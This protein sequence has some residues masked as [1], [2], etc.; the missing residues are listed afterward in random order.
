MVIR[1]E[2]LGT[3]RILCDGAEATDLASLPLPC[4]L[5]VYLALERIADRTDVC[6]FFW[7]DRDPQDASDR[8]DDALGTLSRNLGDGWLRTSDGRLEV[9]DNVSADALEYCEAC[10]SGDTARARALYRGPFLAGAS[11]A[12]GYT[13]AAW[14][15]GWRDW[16][17]TQWRLISRKRPGR[18]WR[19][20]QRVVDRHVVP[21]TL[22]YLAGAW[23]LLEATNFMAGEFGWPFDP[24]PVMTLVLSFGVLSAVTV[25][26]FHG[27]AGFQRISR[28]ELAIH[29][30]IAVALTGTFLVHP[31]GRADMAPG[32]PAYPLTR[33]AVFFFEDHSQP[34][35]LGPLSADLTEAVV[36]RLAN[37]PA[38]DVLPMTAMERFRS[39]SAVPLDSIVARLGIGSF[40]EG[41]VTRR[42]DSIL[43]TAQL[44]ETSS[45]A[46]LDSWTFTE[47]AS[48]ASLSDDLAGFVAEDVRARLGSEVERRRIEAGTRV[49]AALAAYEQA[50]EI[51]EDEAPAEW[52]TDTRRA[53]ALLVDADSAAA[54]AED[55]DPSWT[56][57]ILLR[58]S[59]ADDRSRLMGGVGSRDR[60]MLEQ[61]IAHADR[62]LAVDPEDPSALEWRGRLRYTIA[63]H[64]NAQEARELIRLSEA[65]LRAAVRSDPERPYAWWALSRIMRYRGN[66]EGAYAFAMRAYRSDSFLDLTDEIL[67]ALMDN[68]LDQGRFDDA[69]HWV[70]EGRRIRPGDQGFI[71]RR[72]LIL[73]TLPRPGPADIAAA[74]A[75]VD[76][77]VALGYAER[78]NEWRAYGQFLTAMA[79]A[80]A[81][82]AD[83]ADHVVQR[84]WPALQHASHR[85]QAAGYLFDAVIRERLGQRDSALALLRLYVGLVPSNAPAL[86]SE[87]WF[88]DLWEDPRYQALYSQPTEAAAVR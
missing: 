32:P 12:G 80:A 22:A 52:V 25:A 35:D 63:Q 69:R 49:P 36:H 15:A 29:G 47:A 27:A 4:A 19:L 23:V 74:W 82:Q 3:L 53:A 86:A 10:R 77:L 70:A 65:D 56:A 61:A 33:I 79:L 1:L 21:W 39:G 7:P 54:R 34:G 62:A 24:I 30:L 71:Q 55:L 60:D 59:I 42:G 48:S 68:A 43:T 40:V 13:F 14:S 50:R 2:T 18:G 83:S 9:S 87:T 6:R 67:R 51:T 28:R 64:S 73:A 26:W 41:S 72:L 58:V 5:L 45:N 17:E 44:V 37:V 88:R 78:R 46:H 66:F 57:P 81:G 20:A 8:L 16:L 31:P 85:M 76:T 75:N 38:L 11:A 84:S